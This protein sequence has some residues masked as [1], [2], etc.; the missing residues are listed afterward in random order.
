M[1]ITVCTLNAKYIHTNLAIRYL[2]SYCEDAYNIRIAEYT[3]KDP[4]M[5]IVSDLYSQKPDVIG[6]S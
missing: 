6:F 2:K 3:I 4:A 5:N 1:N